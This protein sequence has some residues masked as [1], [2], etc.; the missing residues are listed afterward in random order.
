MSTFSQT[1]GKCLV[2]QGARL[3]ILLSDLTDNMDYWAT[4]I[5]GASLNPTIGIGGS[6][7]QMPSL[8]ITRDTP[9]QVQSYTDNLLMLDQS[10]VYEIIL[11]TVIETFSG[12]VEGIIIDT[13]ENSGNTF[14]RGFCLNNQG[15]GGYSLVLKDGSATETIDR[16]AYPQ[17]VL[18]ANRISLKF[19]LP[20]KQVTID[21]N[22]TVYEHTYALANALDISG[23]NRTLGGMFWNLENKAVY[24]KM[25]KNEFVVIENILSDIYKPHYLDGKTTVSIVGDSKFYL[26]NGGYLGYQDSIYPYKNGYDLY[27]V[28]DTLKSISVSP[29]NVNGS[30]KNPSTWSDLGQDAFDLFQRI[31]ATEIGYHGI[32]Y[33]E[34]PNIDFFDTTNRTYWKALIE[35]DTYYAGFTPSKKYWFHRTWLDFDWINTHI[36]DAYKYLFFVQCEW[37]RAKNQSYV[38]TK[39]TNIVLFKEAVNYYKSRRDIYSEIDLGNG[40]QSYMARTGTDNYQILHT[41]GLKRV[42]KYGNL[43]KYSDNDG[44]TYSDGFNFATIYPITDLNYVRILDN[45]NIIL[46]SNNTAVHYSDDNLTTVKTSVVKNMDGSDYSFHQSTAHYFYA[47]D[48]FVEHNGIVVFANYNSA[49]ALAAPVNY[50]YSIDF[51]VTWKVFYTYGKNA[52]WFETETGKNLGDPLNPLFTEL[53]HGASF[54]S[55]GNFY[56]F[57]GEVQNHWMKCVYNSDTDTW[58]VTDLLNETSRLWYRM[59]A[60]GGYEKDGYIYWACN[61]SFTTVVGG[62]NYQSS[63]IWKAAIEDI[64]D[65]TKHILVKDTE[66]P[67]LGFRCDMASGQVLNVCSSSIGNFYGEPREIHLSN[68]WGATWETFNNKWTDNLIP[69]HYNTLGKFWIGNNFARIEYLKP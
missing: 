40:Y 31:G 11:E 4:S 18:G 12:G 53:S 39:I 34:M 22:G 36:E 41:N 46:L 56:I 27:W 54:G 66:K 65:I 14:A 47:F 62:T 59:V 61:R 58:T 52:D 29:L 15:N 10:A 1:F 51:G 3:N 30:S 42:A 21:I 23:L 26:T 60:I 5:N 7:K 69:I 16:S 55:D 37:K 20:I 68:D 13:K 64:N 35:A 9:T 48:A 38:K 63:G 32:N 49:D 28:E 67:S 50:Y 45:G 2:Q 17:L 33:I 24:F 57:T 44:L 43:L 25:L 19:N 8:A 6:L